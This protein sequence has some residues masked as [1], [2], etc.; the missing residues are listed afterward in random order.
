MNLFNISAGAAL[1]FA[2][3]W[4]LLGAG[5]LPNLFPRWGSVP[6]VVWGTVPLLIALVLTTLAKLGLLQ[7]LFGTALADF[8]RGQSLPKDLE[9]VEA[10]LAQMD[11][12]P[13]FGKA[14]HLT[15]A[16]HLLSLWGAGMWSGVGLQRCWT[17]AYLYPIALLLIVWGCTG[18]GRL[19][20]AVVLPTNSDSGARWALLLGIAMVATLAGMSGRLLLDGPMAARF[21]RS[22]AWPWAAQLA[23]HKLWRSLL[24]ATLF[25]GALVSF[26]L[27]RS[28]GT[29]FGWIAILFSLAFLL[30]FPA[31]AVVPVFFAVLTSVSKP[32]G[33]LGFGVSLVVAFAS[34][35]YLRSENRPRFRMA[36]LLVATLLASWMLPMFPQ[37]GI[38]PVSFALDL[39]QAPFLLLFFFGIVPILNGLSDWLSINIT[40]KLLARYRQSTRQHARSGWWFHAVDLGSALGLTVL[41]YAV[42]LAVLWLMGQWGWNL[43]LREIVTELQRDPWGGSSQWLLLMAVTNLIP[44]LLHMGLWLAGAA[45]SQD[46]NLLLNLRKSV[47]DVRSAASGLAVRGKDD[48]V[49]GM[50]QA[51]L[52]VYVLKIQPWLERITVFGLMV[53]AVALLGWG[54]PAAAGWML[55]YL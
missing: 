9:L 19:G 41:L 29:I 7:G 55:P 39:S 18:I 27:L 11:S 16:D 6:T 42:T 20:Q 45:R 22:M 34:F 8:R 54:V 3:A 46:S 12:V 32:V 23:S 25:G 51:Q 37:W 10:R 5:D 38:K 21:P 15:R 28:N 50:G 47:A 14:H 48:H 31:V 52:F 43:N 49:V 24:V 13:S 1:V 2:L 33:G 53:F 36:T 17:V 4:W 35:F 26:I 44:T 30:L 40:R